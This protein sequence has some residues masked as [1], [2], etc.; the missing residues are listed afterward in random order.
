MSHVHL[1]AVGGVAGDM[2]AG[3][4][5]DAFPD[6]ED[7]LRRDL[8]ALGGVVEP[9]LRRGTSGGLACLRVEMAVRDAPPATGLWRDLRAF[10]ASAPLHPPVRDG[11]LAIFGHLAA[12]EA[13]CHGV[14][15]EEVHFHEVADWDSVADVVA[16][17]S[18]AHRSGVQ[19]WTVGDLPL[20]EGTVAT[21]HGTLPLPAP[22]TAWLLRGFAVH[23]DGERGERVTPTGAAILRHLVPAPAGRAPRGR[24][25]ATGTGAGT[26]DLAER[27]NILRA[28]VVDTEAA[29]ARDRVARLAFEVDD[30]T[31][32]EV[33]VA[34]DRL[35][36]LP[37]VLDAGLTLGVGKKGRPRFA[38][39]LLARPEGAEALAE[40]CL[41]ETSTLGLRIEEVERRILPRE[42]QGG[43]PRVKRAN[44]PGGATA[45][46]ESDD[47]AVI[48]GLAARRAAARAAEDRGE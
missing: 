47:L 48:P 42:D 27:P 28:L 46:A 10:L 43:E 19:T 13:H 3:A 32:E 40:A 6:L 23:Q 4:L 20:G 8:A 24:L 35:R 15:L 26:R 22:A 2:V 33:A 5:L 18:L 11:A 44:R 14:P 29:P 16:A 31:P 12:A 45:K 36:A 41:L 9:V 21:A 39:D 7:P 34:L 30:M 37:G 17:A 1:D 25:L 38:L